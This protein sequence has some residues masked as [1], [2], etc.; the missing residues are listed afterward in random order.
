MF[1]SPLSVQIVLALAY[2]G[3][4]GE[5]AKELATLL[6]LPDDVEHTKAGYHSLIR[7][8]QVSNSQKHFHNLAEFV[9]QLKVIYLKVIGLS[10]YVNMISTQLF[11]PLRI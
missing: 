3:A 11:F 2:M 6:S 4:R 1:V 10:I 7:V 9:I 8:L 5:T